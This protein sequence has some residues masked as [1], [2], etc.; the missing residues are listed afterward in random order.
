MK[1]I[2]RLKALTPTWFKRHILPYYHFVLAYLGAVYYRHPSKE[3]KVIGITGTKGKSSVNEILTHILEADGH[4]VASVSTI[5]FKLGQKERRNLMK[6][7]MPGRFFLQSF[8]REAVEEGCTHAVIEMTSEGARLHRQ[9]FIE[10]DALIFTNL[11]PEHIESHGSFEA[12]KQAKLAIAKQLERSEKKERYIVANADDEYGADFLET[13]VEHQLPYSLSDLTLYK[14]HKDSISLMFADNTIRAPFIGLF[15][16]YNTLAAITY[17]R[18]EGV[19]WQTIEEALR[20]HPPIKGRVETITT[21]DTADK[22]L[23]IVVDYAHTPDSLKKIYSA[24]PENKKVCVLGNTGGG[25][26]TWKR[27][28]MAKIAEAHCE[29]IILTNEDPYD[30]DPEKIVEEMHRAIENKDKVATIL[31]RRQ[32]IE[33]AIETATNDSVVLVTG[34]GTDPYIM[35]PYGSKT[36]WSDAEVVQEI[37]EELHPTSTEKTA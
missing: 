36:P 14:L 12:Y 2:Y 16:V 22:H 37:L 30:E 18:A 5:K 21:P 33:Y 15:N 10:M 17:A 19:S 9:R 6:M 23:T 1:I 20:N 29:S 27:P 28:E 3:I 7:T 25:R 34:K 31:D 35:G 26:D 32:A 11:S 13:K 24:F 4:T 8:L